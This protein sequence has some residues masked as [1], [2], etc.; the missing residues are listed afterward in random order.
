MCGTLPS[1]LTRWLEWSTERILHGWWVPALAIAAMLLEGA[2]HRASAKC[3][4]SRKVGEAKGETIAPPG[5][6]QIR[7]IFEPGERFGGKWMLTDRALWQDR[8]RKGETTSRVWRL[9]R[10]DS[11]FPGKIRGW[12]E[13]IGAA[14]SASGGL[15]LLVLGLHL[16]VFAVP[17]WILWT[18]LGVG[19]PALLGAVF[20]LA[21]PYESLLIVSDHETVE[22]KAPLG[23]RTALL[24]FGLAVQDALG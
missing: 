13:T 5:P 12:Q 14:A 10:V 21:P 2:R 19:V 22:I 17:G 24:N 15:I 4:V 3:K 7:T 6:D 11:V 8:D 1:H 18:I 9:D 20:F 16:S 23:A